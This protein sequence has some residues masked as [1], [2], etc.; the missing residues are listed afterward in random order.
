MK[1][2]ELLKENN[3]LKSGYVLKSE[4]C[5]LETII[6]LV[7]QNKKVLDIGCHDGTISRLIALN[8]NEV[9][10]IDISEA[11]VNLA[12]EKGILAHKVDIEKDR[13]PFP[14][15]SFD[16]II[17]TE[18]IEHI[19]DTDKFLEKVYSLLKKGSF[20]V[21]TT[22]NLAT[23]GRRILLL[24]GKNPLIEISCDKKAYNVGHI[25][26]FTKTTLLE[27]L[28]KHGFKIDIFR[29]DV[30]NFDNRGTLFS[31]RLAKIFPTLGK[32]LIVKTSK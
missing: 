18:I 2:D 5:R 7:G 28:R 25:R 23:L 30:I 32:T 8:R 6:D 24:M 19:Y 14:K 17:A 13:V 16:V 4:R 15:E 29:S 20:L 10:G 9:H 12:R 27:L 3:F 22:P 26:Y 21:L 11:N 1:L 31:R